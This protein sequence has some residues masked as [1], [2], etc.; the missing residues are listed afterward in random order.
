MSDEDEE[1][2]AKEQEGY[3]RREVSIVHVPV[4]GTRYKVPV[5]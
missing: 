1:T 3:V 4:P 5:L 2:K